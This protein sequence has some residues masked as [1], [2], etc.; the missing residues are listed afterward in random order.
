MAKLILTGD[1][2]QLKPKALPAT[3]AGKR[4]RKLRAFSIQVL[5]KAQKGQLDFDWMKIL[6]ELSPRKES[7]R[8]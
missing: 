2:H 8:K 5:G 4:M 1:S 3:A 7:H 6:P